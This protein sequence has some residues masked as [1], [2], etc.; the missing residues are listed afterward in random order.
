[1]KKL[2]SILAIAAM[3]SFLGRAQDYSFMGNYDAVYFYGIDFHE[4]KCVGANEPAGDFIRAFEGINNLMVSEA[5]K[6]V[7]FI[8]NKL[9]RPFTAV[10]IE[11]TTK[12]LDEIDATEL[13]VVK[14]GNAFSKEDIA[15]IL[16]DLEIEE[17]DGLGL[18]VIAGEL[19]KGTDY[20]TFYYTFFDNKT[21]DVVDVYAY[22][23]KAGG[24]GLRNY[25]A[26]SFYNTIKEIRPSKIYNAAKKVKGGID[27]GV[28][29]VKGE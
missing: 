13:K 19:N 2:I 11:A 6:Y 20:G 3:A 8:E 27:K 10:D 15:F 1:M 26:N 17:K 29:K 25:W 9:G 18:V 14:T 7:S 5:D 4:V 22:K 24:F 21:M 28:S 12:I 23:G 16:P